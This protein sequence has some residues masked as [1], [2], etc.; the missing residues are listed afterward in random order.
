MTGKASCLTPSESIA[1]LKEFN[2]ARHYNSKHKERY[3]NGVGVLRREEVA[4]LER[5]LES[6]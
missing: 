4:A 5:G 3:K 6:Q 1:V 2:I